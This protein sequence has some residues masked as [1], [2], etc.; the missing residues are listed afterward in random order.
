LSSAFQDLL[1]LSFTFSIA[2]LLFTLWSLAYFC[3]PKIPISSE[4]K[5]DN[6]GMTYLEVANSVE[7]AATNSTEGTNA[8]VT[9]QNGKTYFVGDN[10]GCYYLS[11]T[12]KVYVGMFL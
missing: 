1:V 7:E 9:N 10:G 3:Y 5:Q 12:K 6:D 8:S 4:L 2:I 11:G